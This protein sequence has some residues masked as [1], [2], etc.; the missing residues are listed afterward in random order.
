MVTLMGSQLFTLLELDTQHE[1]NSD[2]FSVIM[3]AV[4]TGEI[5]LLVTNQQQI[6]MHTA[7]HTWKV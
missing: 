6:T 4:M 1:A 3:L 7:K 2:R 5:F